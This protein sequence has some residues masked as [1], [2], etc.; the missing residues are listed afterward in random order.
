M[1]GC[2]EAQ[3]RVAI[4]HRESEGDG[5]KK[6]QVAVTATATATA[7]TTTTKAQDTKPVEKESGRSPRVA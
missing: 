6:P 5:V 1:G 2:V 3:A 7:M 4:V